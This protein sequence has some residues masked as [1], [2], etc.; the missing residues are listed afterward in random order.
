MTFCA[1]VV[2]A[3]RGERFGQPKQLVEVAGR[4]LAAWSLA[5]VGAMP[6]L[7]DVVIATE[8]QSILTFER[9]AREFAPRLRAMVVAGG[10][11]RQESVAR[12]LA[13]VPDRCDAVFVHDGARPLLV[14]ADVRAGMA[15]TASGTGAV[16]AAPV[17][18]TIKVVAPDSRSVVRTLDRTELWAAQ[19]PQFAM[20]ADLRAA[21]A[22][23]A[24]AAFVGT[25]E[26]MLLERA[27]YR[28]V[29]VP[30]SGENFKVTL[31][32]DRDRAEAILRR[33]MG[34]PASAA[35]G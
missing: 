26:A 23:A 30:A 10:A 15:V 31:P 13:A 25:D 32:G 24:A 3:G 2:A 5:T 21:H 9:L 18:D 7:G 34:V 1:V 17:A 29:V 6:E 28:V 11:T 22:A 35:A 14:A 8:P 20:L 27:G 16:L 19:T 33:R 4:P 12:A